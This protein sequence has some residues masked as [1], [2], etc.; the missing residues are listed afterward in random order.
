MAYEIVMPQLSDSMTEGKLISWKVKPGD[1][2]KVGDTIAEV[3]SD[4]AIMEVQTFHDGIVRELKVK[5]GE[6]APVGSVIAVIEETS[7][8]EQQRNEQPSNR[9]T[10]QPV[11]T[12]PSNEELGT[13][14]EERNNRVTEQPSN[15]QPM[16]A[17]PSNEELGMR[18][19]ESKPSV[20]SEQSKDAKASKSNDQR[21]TTN[22][23]SS[24]RS[25]S[26][27]D[28]LFSNET[29]VSEKTPHSSLLTP[30]SREAIASPR[31]R[32][33]AARYGLDLEKLQKKG[34]LPTPA[35]AEDIERYR[36]RKYFTPKAWKLVEEY[37]LDPALF[38]S[39]KKHNE[40]EIKAYIE[41]H[42]IPR[43]KP[44]SSN[45]KAVIATVEQ[46]AKTPVYHIYDHI[47]ASLILQHE[48]D[49]LTV[50]VWL[51][52]LLSETMMRHE[53]LRSTL[54]PQGIQIWPNASIS[55]AIAK[56][57]ELYMPVLKDLNKMSPKEIT[58]ALKAM[59]E[60]VKER[61]L[62]P[63]DMRGSTFGLS[64]LGMTGIERFDAMINGTDSGIAAIGST[65]DGKIAVTF[66]LDHR[67]VNGL[68]G[69][70]AM[71]T[72]KTLAKDEMIFKG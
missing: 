27:V 12:A 23:R 53:V 64:N 69:A 3:E 72:L 1:K 66:T 11:K 47:D 39:G 18:N 7:D 49:E 30:H 60:K 43:P 28:E 26:I 71:E 65:I 34:E 52:K 61:R 67:L 62:S 55:L 2:V 10:E 24:Q 14:N 57:E 13:R 56:G 19:E 48:S 21:P 5:E 6:S 31:A 45:Q 35:H 50:T 20:S 37:Q 22:D 68:Q 59:K 17:A 8:N 15:E 16:K 40:E 51:L 41:A 54:G 33:L 38:D 70:Q 9:A 63:Q 4:K 25:K 42:E 32:A 36:Q 29:P 44:L 46:A 58:D